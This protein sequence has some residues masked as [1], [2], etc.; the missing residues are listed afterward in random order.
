MSRP[1]QIDLKAIIDG[2]RIKEMTVAFAESCTG[3]RLA[4]DL[5]TIPGASDVVIGSVVAYQ[6]QAKNCV[7]GLSHVTERN[8]VS[9]QTAK[10]MADVARK[11]FD[12]TVAIATTGYLDGNVAEAV[13]A[14]SWSLGTTRAE[15]VEHMSPSLTRAMNRELV[16]HQAMSELMTFAKEPNG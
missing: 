6:I 4:A 12:S 16:I 1:V 7:L 11:M 14:V 8:V 15:W 5:T 13:L 9:I 10:D 2:L 3:G